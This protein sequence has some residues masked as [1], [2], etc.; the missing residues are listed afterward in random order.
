MVVA[1]LYK[2]LTSEWTAEGRDWMKV[3]LADD[4]Y[5]NCSAGVGDIVKGPPACTTVT[6]QRRRQQSR[7]GHPLQRRAHPQGHRT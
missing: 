3:Q 5:G 4:G 6:I 2:V 1:C 7:A